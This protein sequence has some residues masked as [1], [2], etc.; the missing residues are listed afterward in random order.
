MCSNIC[1]QMYQNASY[2]DFQELYSCVDGIKY[3]HPLKI[4]S[5]KCASVLDFPGGVFDTPYV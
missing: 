3:C 5:F 2:N 1:E 4:I